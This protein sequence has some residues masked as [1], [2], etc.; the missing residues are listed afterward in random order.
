MNPTPEEQRQ[1][2]TEMIQR[3]QGQG[4]SPRQFTVIDDY[5]TFRAEYAVVD[6]DIIVQFF[7]PVEAL[8]ARTG[9]TIEEAAP[10][11]YLRDG[12]GSQLSTPPAWGALHP[13]TQATWMQTVK[14]GWAK[15][16]LKHDEELRRYWMETFPGALQVSAMGVFAAGPPRLQ[17]MFIEE[18]SSWWFKALGFVVLRP[19]EL[20][21]SFVTRLDQD[22]D[23]AGAGATL[24]PNAR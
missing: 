4:I 9:Q 16:F 12:R 19:N 21:R 5:T 2:A 8:V 1:Q 18:V 7:L 17:A 24:A 3:E 14:D 15:H 10:Q 11:L 23:A 20:V 6:N 22:L 13:A